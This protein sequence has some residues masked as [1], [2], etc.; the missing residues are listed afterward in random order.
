MQGRHGEQKPRDVQEQG[1]LGN[2]LF[3]LPHLR[4]RA[5]QSGEISTGHEGTFCWWGI[6]EVFEEQDVIWFIKGYSGISVEGN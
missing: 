2:S 3:K 4:G 5:D 6:S 1:T